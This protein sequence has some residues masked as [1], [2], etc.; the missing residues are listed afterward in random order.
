MDQPKGKTK[1]VR[2]TEEQRNEVLRFIKEYNA[3]N[4]RGGQKAAAGKY[5]ITQITLSNWMK[6]DRHAAKRRTSTGKSQAK[7]LLPSA[8]YAALFGKLADL[9]AQIA[10]L[11]KQTER[12][13]ALR[14]EAMELQRSLTR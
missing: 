9:H 4:K 3:A 8:E 6:K 11:E 5:N 10:I 2:Y 1:R 7:N 12:L 13:E 14:Q